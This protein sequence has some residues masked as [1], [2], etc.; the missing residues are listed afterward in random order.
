MLDV[1]MY[2]VRVLCTMYVYL[3]TMY[4]V[5]T[6]ERYAWSQRIFSLSCIAVRG[7][8]V[9]GYVRCTMYVLV[10]CTRRTQKN[11]NFH[12]LVHRTSYIVNGYLQV[13][14]T[15][16]YVP[17][18]GDSSHSQ[19][20]LFLSLALRWEENY[21][22]NNNENCKSKIC[23]NILLIYVRISICDTPVSDSSNR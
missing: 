9:Q 12:V 18:V 1:C 22:M 8:D 11:E 19:P 20:V 6:A 15:R 5:H 13:R 16:Y 14:C 21:N 2:I 3:C 10:R 17:P 23:I 7:Y 4:D